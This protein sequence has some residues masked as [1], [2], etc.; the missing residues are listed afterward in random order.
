MLMDTYSFGM[1]VLW[2]VS[3]VGQIHSD[4]YFKL[5]SGEASKAAELIPQVVDF[6]FRNQKLDL[7]PFF[8]VTLT[9][10]TANRCSDFQHLQKLLS[11]ER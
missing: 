10:D 8:N 3:R 2:L 1:L 7:D 4:R 9:H 6:S 11:P 5:G